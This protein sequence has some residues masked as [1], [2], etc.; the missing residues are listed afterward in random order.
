[1]RWR[2]SRDEFLGAHQKTNCDR[3]ICVQANESPK[4]AK[5]PVFTCSSKAFELQANRTDHGPAP[6]SHLG[7]PELPR[8]LQRMGNVTIRDVR[9]H[10][11]KSECVCAKS[12]RRTLA[13]PRVDGVTP[14][15]DIR[16]I[17]RHQL[18]ATLPRVTHARVECSTGYAKSRTT[19][20][21]C[22]EPTQHRQV[23]G[24]LRPCTCTWQQVCF[25]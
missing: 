18:C 17:L 24:V 9:A 11:T 13:S 14:R 2:R 6:E 10:P 7:P 15:G 16:P 23:G 12:A 3:R 1:M 19:E 25:R 4:L 21:L 20:H 22:T 8:V 5:S